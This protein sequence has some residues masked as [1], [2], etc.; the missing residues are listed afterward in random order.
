MPNTQNAFIWAVS[1]QE[2]GGNYAAQNGTS[3]AAG[4]WQIMPANIAPWA[5]ECGMPVFSLGYFLTHPRYQDRM[6]Q[7][8]LGRDYRTWGPRGAASVWYSGQ[9]NWHATY[10]NPPVYAYVNSVIAIMGRWHG[11]SPYSGGGTVGGG[12]TTGSTG[13]GGGGQ[14]DHTIHPPR[15]SWA[16]TVDAS[17]KHVLHTGRN[18]HAHAVFIHHL[19]S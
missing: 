4:K 17:A 9:P 14:V 15:A 13:G 8:K 18:L 5:R 11:Q 2:S 12:G 10:G 1:I 3:G 6:A 19:R 16:P 7:C